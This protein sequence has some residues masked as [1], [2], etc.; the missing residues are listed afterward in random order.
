MCRRFLALLS[1][2]L[3]GPVLAAGLTFENALALAEAHAPDLKAATARRDGAR[4][5][6]EAADALPD[7]RAFVG[8]DNLP[9]EGPDRFSLKREEEAPHDATSAPGASN[10]EWRC[11]ASPPIF[12]PYP[13]PV[14]ST[15]M[16]SST[17]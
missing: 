11:V 1:L 8:V 2:L 5:A 12:P 3:A 10:F 4:E 14:S 16:P 7:P 6:V 9:V 13:P 15:Q 17:P